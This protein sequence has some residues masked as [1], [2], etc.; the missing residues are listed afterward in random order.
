MPVS[1][2]YV[3]EQAFNEWLSIPKEQLIVIS[4]VIEM[5]HNASLLCVHRQSVC[6]SS[7]LMVLF[8]TEW[9]T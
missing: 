6:A 5:L 7:C 8:R 3:L 9:M 1:C 4:E 2:F